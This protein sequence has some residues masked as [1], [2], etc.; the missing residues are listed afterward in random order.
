[1]LLPNKTVLPGGLPER[2]ELAAALMR[3]CQCS[4]AAAGALQGTITR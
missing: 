4:R 3:D 2:S 1:M